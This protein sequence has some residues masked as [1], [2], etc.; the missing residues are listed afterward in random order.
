MAAAM[1]GIALHGFF[2][3]YGGTFLVFSDYCR[4]SIRLSALMKQRVIYVFTHDS[5]G[6]GEDGPTHQPIEHLS[7][8]RCIPN[9]KVFRP[10][11]SVETA[12]CWELAILNKGGPSVLAL[13]RQNLK[14]LRN[15]SFSDSEN[16]SSKGAYGLINYKNAVLNIIAT[17]SEVEIAFAASNK[18]KEKNIKANVISMPCMELFLNLSSSQKKEIIGERKNIIIEAGTIQSWGS[19]MRDNDI[20]IGLDDFGASGPGKDVYDHFEITVNK[21]LDKAEIILDNKKEK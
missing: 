9:L 12:E 8:L 15:K 1:N 14:L 20:F 10:C 21:I 19:I 6:L 3:P 17:G 4:P 7:S 13:S 11:D 16:I 18:L 2:I 5:I